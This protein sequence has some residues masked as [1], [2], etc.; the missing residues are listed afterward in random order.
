MLEQSIYTKAW[1]RTT[2]QPNAMSRTCTT[3]YA[4]W[5]RHLIKTLKIPPI[6][7]D[8]TPGVRLVHALKES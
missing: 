6:P 5:N 3:Y 2:A 1:L 4:I 8:D 7:P